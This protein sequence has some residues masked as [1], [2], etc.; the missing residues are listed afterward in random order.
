[1]GAGKTTF[2]QFL[3]QA[4]GIE[5]NVTS[6]TYNYLKTYSIPHQN[7]VFVH[8]DAYRLKSNEDVDS[9]GL[10]DYIT[11][12][13]TIILIEWVNNIIDFLPAKTKLINFK[14]EGEV[15]LIEGLLI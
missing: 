8:V 11:D 1:M 9:I 14:V 7:L 4:L 10:N 6:P 13:N 12:S 5:E 2:T 3:A 15:R